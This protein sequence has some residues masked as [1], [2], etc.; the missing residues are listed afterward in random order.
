MKTPEDADEDSDAAL[1]RAAMAAIGGL[2]ARGDSERHPARTPPPPATASFSQADERAVLAQLLALPPDD[3][4][5]HGETLSYSAPGVQD[6]VLR[7]LRRG[8]YRIEREL[9]LHG[10]NRQHARLA[11]DQFLAACQR[12]A[13][14]CIRIIHGKGNGSPNSGP[15]L[16]QLVGGWLRKRRDVLAYA[17]ARSV[18]GGSGALYVLLRASR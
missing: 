4:L 16:K 13:L 5:D 1:F 6:G 3:E 18:D 15:I 14:R 17:S 9:D 10:Y 12:D 8:H 11:V 2:R 7:R